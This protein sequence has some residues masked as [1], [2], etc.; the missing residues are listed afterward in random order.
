MPYEASIQK[1]FS[2]ILPLTWQTNKKW[3]DKNNR[4]INHFYRICYNARIWNASIH[5]FFISNVGIPERD[6]KSHAHFRKS[7][8]E[9]QHIWYMKHNCQSS[10]MKSK[11]PN[12][13]LFFL[14][15]IIRLSIA[16]VARVT[17]RSTIVAVSRGEAQ[18]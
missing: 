17:D 1:C 10:R 8:S 12:N 14:L 15:W 13:E 6:P 2:I 3:T 9:K 18:G 5:Q 7:F 16:F 4:K 11:L